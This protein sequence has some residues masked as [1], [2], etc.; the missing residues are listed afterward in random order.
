MRSRKTC[1]TFKLWIKQP[2]K[3]C[4]LATPGQSPPRRASELPDESTGSDCADLQPSGS[5]FRETSFRHLLRRRSPGV[6]A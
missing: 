4:H 2:P 5:A 6:R 3:C 1:K